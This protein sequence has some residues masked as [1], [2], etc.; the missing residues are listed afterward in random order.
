MKLMKFN[1]VRVW[2]LRS[3][4]HQYAFITQFVSSV[5][6]YLIVSQY[7]AVNATVRFSVSCSKCYNTFSGGIEM[8]EA[9]MS[10]QCIVVIRNYLTD[11]PVI[12]R[13]PRHWCTGT[14]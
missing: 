3:S 8:R 11:V 12:K 4:S 6:I 2:N 5:A 10:M 14:S 9:E 1:G 13:G 7:P